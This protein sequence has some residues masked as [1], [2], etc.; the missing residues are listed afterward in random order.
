MSFGYKHG[1]PMEADWV[2]DVR[3]IPIPYYVSSL[4]KLTGNNIKVAQYVM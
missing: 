3:F 1:V 2:L 4:K